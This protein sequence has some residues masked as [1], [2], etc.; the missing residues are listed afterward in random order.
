MGSL[1]HQHLLGIYMSYF[2]HRE[3]GDAVI[4]D[5]GLLEEISLVYAICVFIGPKSTFGNHRNN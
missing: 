2:L 1:E 5:V 4:E 3:T